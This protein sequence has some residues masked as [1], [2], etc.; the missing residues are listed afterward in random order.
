VVRDGRVRDSR[1]VCPS[2]YNVKTDRRHDRRALTADAK[3]AADREERE[4]SGSLVYRDESGRVAD[5]HALR[6]TLITSRVRGGADPRVAQA[7]A[8]HPA[9]TLTMDRY[10]HPLIG[11]PATGLAALPEPVAQFSSPRQPSSTG[12]GRTSSAPCS[13]QTGRRCPRAAVCEKAGVNRRIRPPD[14]FGIA[15]HA[16]AAATNKAPGLVAANLTHQR[17]SAIRLTRSAI[18]NPPQSAAL[19]LTRTWRARLS[20]QCTGCRFSKHLTTRILGTAPQRIP[21]TLSGE[22]ASIFHK[23]NR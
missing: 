19:R 3:A 12:T 18:G 15:E 9:I 10:S 11:Q 7:L 21:V 5:F 2:R 23:S 6:R 14:F 22:G 13:F 4:G 16:R 8:R 17:W 20:E 1:V